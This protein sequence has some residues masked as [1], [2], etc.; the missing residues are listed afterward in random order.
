MGSLIIFLF[1]FF[2]IAKTITVIWKKKLFSSI[3][4]PSV[5]LFLDPKKCLTKLICL[6]LHSTLSDNFEE[7]FG[8]L[9][10]TDPI[11]YI[12]TIR[13]LSFSVVFRHRCWHPTP[14]S[15]FNIGRSRSNKRM[16]VLNIVKV[17]K[18]RY[19][20]RVDEKTRS[21]TVVFNPSHLN[22]IYVE[23]ILPNIRAM[24]FLALPE[25]RNQMPYNRHWAGWRKKWWGRMRKKNINHIR[26]N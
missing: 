24:V 15:N 17:A 1:L 23:L 3:F 13:K 11:T 22:H 16:K 12:H 5:L 26:M 2:G 7:S 20:E 6:S 21:Q 10:N 18:N 19:C 25:Y 8:V 14:I 9:Y 4:I